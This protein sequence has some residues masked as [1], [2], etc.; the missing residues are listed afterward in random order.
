MNIGTFIVVV[1]VIYSLVLS[2]GVGVSLEGF[3]KNIG[4][5][6]VSSLV[7]RGR[8][9][10]GVV[11]G[12]L[13]GKNEDGMLSEGLREDIRLFVSTALSCVK[14][15]DGDNGRAVVLSTALSCLTRKDGDIARA[16]V[17]VCV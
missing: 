10:S 3:R 9:E 17:C 4:L 11:R 15:K 8:M 7:S 13:E 14:G 5:F 6:V 2:Q 16:G 1:V 12:L